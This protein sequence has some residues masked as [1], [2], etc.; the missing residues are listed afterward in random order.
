MTGP[1]TDYRYVRDL[2]A[3]IKQLRT[4]LEAYAD[5]EHWQEMTG[6]FLV[7]ETDDDDRIVWDCGAIARAALSVC[8]PEER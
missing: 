2:E 6:E 8:E 3:E 5:P 4:A 1:S 7:H